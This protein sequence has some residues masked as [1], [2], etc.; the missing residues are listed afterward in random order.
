MKI[1]KVFISFGAIGLIV[2][3][4]FI[5]GFDKRESSKFERSQVSHEGNESSK[6]DENSVSANSAL[7]TPR[8]LN[9]NTIEKETVTVEDKIVEESTTSNI[10]IDHKSL[11][12]AMGATDA[13]AWQ[14]EYDLGVYNPVYDQTWQDDMYNRAY[15]LVL[16]EDFSQD[17]EMTN[18][19]CKDKRCDIKLSQLPSSEKRGGQL[20]SDFILS[21]K[22]HPAIL[23][24][25]R[26]RNVYINS[27][28]L[29]DGQQRLDASIY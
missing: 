10:N 17:I 22:D 28:E 27:I 12:K 1:N 9:K 15:E 14:E 11:L 25:G 23:E 29:I 26:K 3:V 5:G 2:I 20:A 7:I 8:Q 19:E 21:L 16:H 18:I 13:L 6:K 4:L 24:S